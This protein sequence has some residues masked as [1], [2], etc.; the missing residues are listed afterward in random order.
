MAAGDT[1][2]FCGGDVLTGGSVFRTRYIVSVAATALDAYKS[3]DLALTPAQ[4]TTLT[5][6]VTNKIADIQ[7]LEVGIVFALRHLSV[8][9]D[10]AGG[11]TVKAWYVV[12]AGG[13]VHSRVV[14]LTAAQRTTL[15]SFMATKIAD[16][17]TIEQAT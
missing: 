13:V 7:A 4:V 2:L 12:T 5:T 16:L 6:F 1:L 9:S 10:G 3:R 17:Q 14:T 8:V 11:W 15:N